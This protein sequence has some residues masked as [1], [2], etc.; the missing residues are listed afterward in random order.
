LAIENIPNIED[1]KKMYS[2]FL[3]AYNEEREHGGG[4]DGH[5]HHLKCFFLK[6][7]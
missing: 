1:G 3:K 5:V 2:M 6:E 4:I 7:D